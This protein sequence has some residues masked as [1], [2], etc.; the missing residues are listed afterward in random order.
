MERILKEK[1]REA[2]KVLFN[3]EVNDELFQVQETRKD[4]RGDFTLVVFPLN[5]LP[6]TPISPFTWDI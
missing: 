2:V 5:I 3:T 4:F 1:I 6:P